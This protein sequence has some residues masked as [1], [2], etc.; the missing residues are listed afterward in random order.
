MKEMSNSFT[1]VKII[2]IGCG[3]RGEVYASYALKYPK[4]A[5]V[6]GIADPRA[7]ARQKF[8]HIY[9]NTIEKD[10]VFSD[11]KEAV[12]DSRC[13]LADM[14]IIALPDKLHMEAAIAFTKKGYHILL[15][16]PMATLLEECKNITY[17]CREQQKLNSNQFN[18]VCHVL[19]Y[20]SPNIKIR[21]MIESGL[22]GDVV[23]INHVEP[24]GYWH[25][26]HSFVRGNWHNEN[27][28]SFSLLAKCCHDIDLIVYWMSAQKKK[29]VNVS[30]FGSLSHFRKEKAPVGSTERCLECPCEPVCCY[31]AKKLY[32]SDRLATSDWPVSVVLS[33]EIT[34]LKN[35]ELL[36][37]ADIEDF[38][39]SKN[40]HEKRQLLE[41]CLRHEKTKYGRCVYKLDNDVC[42]NQVVNMQ[43]NDG[44]TATM[45]M[46]AFTK[47]VCSRKT[48]IYGTK[49]ELEFDASRSSNSIIHYDFLTNK[50]TTIDSTECIKS[51][52]NYRIDEE[53]NTANNNKHIKLGGHDG[54]DFWIMH[55]I[56]QA[57]L[58]K[59]SSFILTD[60]EDSFRSHL[61]VFAA[62]HSRK[63]NRIVDVAE[64]CNENGIK[65]ENY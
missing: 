62:E 3:S 11:W 17:A 8:M 31:S 55:S 10:K 13:S 2:I 64:F 57:I 24:V 44:A 30:S 18:A 47:D 15:E 1:G 25:F 52:Q 32:M 56:I 60:V 54:S 27:Q 51:M 45:T 29:C 34:N 53:E 14:A 35:D 61:I 12:E 20:Y 33:S 40:E 38:L 6:V 36:G 48:K 21:Q 41:K 7:H 23:N 59:D 22:I 16:K 58:S 5:C 39:M 9:G 4:R 28:S 46:I 50:T 49:G 26:A 42:D 43:F 65:I 37:Q 19:R 63:Q